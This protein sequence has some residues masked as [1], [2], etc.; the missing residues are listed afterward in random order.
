VSR[1]I[2]FYVRSIHA[3]N[4]D[5][6]ADELIAD[7]TTRFLYVKSQGHRDVWNIK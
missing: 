2:P 7:G 1:D 5:E 6:S 4:W 3:G